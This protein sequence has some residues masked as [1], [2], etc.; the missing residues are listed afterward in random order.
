MEDVK[1]PLPFSG[2]CLKCG[3]PMKLIYVSSDGKAKFYQCTHPR[4]A[5]KQFLEKQ[6]E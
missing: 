3:R 6:G 2:K 1:L 4:K 5:L